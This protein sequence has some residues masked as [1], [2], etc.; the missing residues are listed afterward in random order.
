[1]FA[2]NHLWSYFSK[3]TLCCLVR[4]LTTDRLKQYKFLECKLTS[5]LH[6]EP[7]TSQL[8]FGF[9]HCNDWK[10]DPLCCKLIL[11]LWLQWLAQIYSSWAYDLKLGANLSIRDTE[12]AVKWNAFRFFRSSP[13][14]FTHSFPFCL[15]VPSGVRQ[16]ELHVSL[17][18]WNCRLQWYIRFIYYKSVTFMYI[19]CLYYRAKLC[20]HIPVLLF[21]ICIAEA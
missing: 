3:S 17:V 8:S 20:P 14:I 15:L 21:S 2:L 10:P 9:G 16:E 11:L 6:R 12:R 7:E 1:M 4:F 13:D 5:S 18:Q 19:L